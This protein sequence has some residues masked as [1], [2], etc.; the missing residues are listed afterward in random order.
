[1]S[2]I[3]KGVQVQLKSGGPIMT[4][5]DIGDYLATGIQDGALCVWF[6]GNKALEKVFGIAALQVYQDD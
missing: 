2:E 3:V 5:Q 1:M 6:A 4:V